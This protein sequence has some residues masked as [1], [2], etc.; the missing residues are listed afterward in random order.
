MLSLQG[1]IDLINDNKFK[2]DKRIVNWRKV[3]YGM[4]LHIRGI[5]PAFIDMRYETRPRVT[6]DYL[7][8]GEYQEIFEL[9]LFSRHP[10]EEEVTR[11][12]RLSQ[13]KPL[14][15]QPFQ[16]A[17]EVITGAI[18]QDSGY[19]IDI[20]DETDREY[21]WGNNFEGRDLPSYIV[22]S[23]QNI[24]ED[25]NGVFLVIPEH[26][27]TELGEEVEPELKFI[28]SRYILWHTDDE[29]IYED[30][31]LRWAVN[32]FGYFRFR[33][34]GK[35]YVNIDPQGYYYAHMLTKVPV[36]TAGGTWN[37]QGYFDSWLD[38]AK[39]LA[40]EFIGA[41]SA[42]QLVNK[43]ASHPFIIEVDSECPE[44]HG[45]KQVS[46][47][48]DCEGAGCIRCNDGYRL[49]N[50]GTCKGAG[51]ISHNPGQRILAPAQD[52]SSNLVQIVNPDVS[53]NQFHVDNNKD[54]ENKI[55]AALHLHFIDQA[56][57]GVA[58]SKDMET[59]YQFISRI[60]NDI[61][62]RLIPDM[63]DHILGL[64]N[65]AVIDGTVRP[66][67]PS[68]TI[69]KPSDFQIKTSY[70]LLEE[71]KA[72]Q[73]SKI[74]SYQLA[75]L[76][77]DYTDKQFAGNEILKKKTKIINQMDVL[78]VTTIGDMQIMVMNNYASD[79]D[80]QLHVQLPRILD[81]IIRD[82]GED[83]F[84]SAPFDTIEQQALQMFDSIKPPVPI[85]QP[86]VIDLNRV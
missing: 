19:R 44:C 85:I 37:T 11:N 3:F 30:G 45:A 83:W 81:K 52:M 61:F 20:P 22:H 56:Q 32:K 38:A 74:P 17:I 70:D 54:M 86:D 15:K 33:K 64:R 12:W 67:T 6:P 10:R 65:V 13:Y 75:A 21:I 18:F 82:K 51:V 48:C 8:C 2:A 71:M 25:P 42:E 36:I 62:D 24:C 1:I 14:T 47:Q 29:I 23:F 69:V 66:S 72:G 16:R 34:E 79:R 78:A 40:D 28:N 9:Y 63:L 43:E 77:E 80:A 49:I 46:I 41:K 53:I 58:K 57:S 84:L 50:C 73:D 7:W 31:D 5:R 27:I 39:P 68:Y 26:S 55:L 59:R 4:S 76:L 60:S 35:V